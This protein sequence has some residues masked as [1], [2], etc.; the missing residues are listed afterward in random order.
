MLDAAKTNADMKNR[1]DFYLYRVPEEFYDLTDDRCERRNLIADPSRQAE[2]DS[3]RQE[4]LA[5][6]RRTGDPYAEA[7]ALRGRRDL[8]ADVTETLNQEYFGGKKRPT[9]KE[10]NQ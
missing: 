10:A 3:M 1:T 4:L 9:G 8:V 5:L 7:F 2:I 6:M